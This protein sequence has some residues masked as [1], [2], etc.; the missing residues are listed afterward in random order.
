MAP[1]RQVRF[2]AETIGRDRPG[3]RG[4]NHLPHQTFLQ[5]KAL[6]SIFTQR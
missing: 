2:R 3:Q 5:V 6:W 4:I 1:K